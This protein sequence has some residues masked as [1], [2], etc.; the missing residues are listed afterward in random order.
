MSAVESVAGFEFE[1]RFKNHTAALEAAS[2]VSGEMQTMR[3]ILKSGK[4]I[5]GSQPEIQSSIMRLAG[6]LGFPLSKEQ[7]EKMGNTD[8]FDAMVTNVILPKMKL[9][10][11]N[12]SEQEL[13]VIRE[14]T[15]SRKFT[16]ETLGRILEV[17]EK[18]VKKR[19]TLEAEYRKHVQ[20]GKGRTNFNFY[21]EALGQVTTEPTPAVVPAK[22]SG[23]PGIPQASSPTAAPV[24]IPDSKV[25]NY[26]AYVKQLT[27]KDITPEQ[28]RQR[29]EASRPKGQ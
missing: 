26:I 25:Q 27:G 17:M 13:K 20:A 4:L 11:G 7:L 23:I 5:T 2:S 28:A 14:S 6:T 21:P 19:Y 9:L 29:L 12:D 1:S 16:I 15:G 8:T 24:V 3:D 10:G 22:P 18:A